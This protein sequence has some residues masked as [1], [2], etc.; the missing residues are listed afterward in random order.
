VLVVAVPVETRRAVPLRGSRRG[1]DL[2]RVG[3][4]SV[5]SRSLPRRLMILMGRLLKA[6]KRM[7][8]LFDI[9]LSSA[10]AGQRSLI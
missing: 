6:W 8:F 7:T 4:S 10:P 3:L 9:D 5:R 2:R 1:R